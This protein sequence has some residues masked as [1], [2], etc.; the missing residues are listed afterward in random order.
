MAIRIYASSL[1]HNLLHL[2]PQFVEDILVGLVHGARTIRC[3][4]WGPIGGHDLAC[5]ERFGFRVND[6]I[7]D[8][9]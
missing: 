2:N 6:D 3:H 7:A 5:L 4:D 1:T 8:E 9:A